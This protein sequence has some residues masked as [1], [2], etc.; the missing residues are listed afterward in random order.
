I[1][2][3]QYR[4]ALELIMSRNPLPDSVCRVC[5]RPCEQVCV[6]AGTDE[7]VAINDLKRFVMDWA[8]SQG[9]S[10]YDPECE[11]SGGMKVAVVGAGPAG[12]AA[13]HDLRLRGY[14]V[15]LFDANEQPGGMLLTGIPAFR[16]PRQALRR[17]VDRILGLGVEFQ[18]NTVLGRDLDLSELT[19]GYDAVF[20]GLGAQRPIAL[21]VAETDGSDGRPAMVDALAYL[22]AVSHLSSSGGTAGTEGSVVVVGGGNAAIDAARTALR[23]GAKSVA[24]AYRRSRAEMPALSE[25][26]EAAAQEGVELR[27]H[28]QPV[29]IERGEDAGL[30][31]VR[32]E[33]GERDASGRRRPVAVAGS[34]VLLA[35]DLLIVAIGQT[36]DPSVTGDLRLAT[37]AD[38]SLEIDSETGRTSH[39]KIFAGGDQTGGAR[40]VTDAIALGQRAAWGIDHTL[41]GPRAAG[42]LAP[43]PRAG[44]WPQASADSPHVRRADRAPRQRPGEIP[45]EQRL[46]GFDEVVGVLSEARARAEAAR[47]ETCGQCANCRACLDLFGCPAFYLEDGLIRINTAL[48]NGC[49]ACADFCPNGAIRPVESAAHSGQE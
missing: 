23:R 6:R 38:G 22:A 13:A 12:L 21:E 30:V 27:T 18:G 45:L 41:R 34:E 44:T 48:C 33:P 29:A 43:P 40:T 11:P 28:L 49:G 8:A 42:R 32:T 3:G 2:A 19:Q 37:A 20:L 31:C 15:T 47:C 9:G 7:P 17:D 5:H 25:E 16:L 39:P 14:G 10:P 26:I 24:V 46:A 1:A 4:D 35:A 36:P